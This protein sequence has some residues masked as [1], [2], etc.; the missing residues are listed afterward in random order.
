MKA[1]TLKYIVIEYFPH[2]MDAHDPKPARIDGHYSD[3]ADAEEVAALW[4]EN[5]LHSESRIIVSEIVF[6]AKQPAHWIR[7]AS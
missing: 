3:R 1:T 5:P 2:A 6:E 7:A 4:A